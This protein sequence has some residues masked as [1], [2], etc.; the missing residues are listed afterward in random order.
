MALNK[1]KYTGMSKTESH[2]VMA[3]SFDLY[4]PCIDPALFQ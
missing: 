3:V 2:V 1:V 4:I